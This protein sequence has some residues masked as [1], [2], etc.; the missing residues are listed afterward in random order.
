MLAC[1]R[2]HESGGNYTA[3]NGHGHTGAYQFDRSTWAS[4]GGTGEAAD[5]SPEEQDARAAELL[6]QRG[7]QPWSV[8]ERCR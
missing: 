8:R 4:V 1:L 6:R 7:L 3:R 2:R 5:A